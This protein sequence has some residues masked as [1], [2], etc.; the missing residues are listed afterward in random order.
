MRL[1]TWYGATI[2]VRRGT[3]AQLDGITLAA[4]ELGFTTDDEKELWVG[5]GSNNLLVGRAILDTIGNIPT[6]AVAGR[7]FYATDTDELFVD[8]GSSWDEISFDIA[9]T[10]DNLVSLDANGKPQDS[11]VAVDDAGTTTADLWTASKIQTEIDNAVE[12][13]SWKEPASVMGLVGNAAASTIE[14]LSPSAGDSYVVTTAD[15]SGELA[16][17]TVGDIWEYNGSAWAKVIT[18]SGGFVPSGTRAALST[19][20][21]LISPY[22]DATDDGKVMSFNGTTNTGSNTGDAAEGNAIL[23][24]G[25]NSVNEN[26]TYSFDGTVPTGSWV[27]MNQGGGLSAGN[28]ILI[29]SNIISVKPDSTTGGNVIPVDVS[30]NGVGL[31]VDDLDGTGLEVDSAT[32]RLAA[33]GNGISGGAGSTLSV[34]SDTATG[35][36]IA[37]VSVTA[38][39]VGVK[40]DN[41]SIVHDN[42]SPDEISVALVD[43]G[44]F[45]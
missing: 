2:Q 32:L 31:D 37:A 44:S 5:D 3:K 10:E 12:G 40:I 41:S 16:T 14:G 45:A 39:G 11:G 22:T 9:G 19:A 25:E 42:G 20:T 6:A 29:S 43:G 8:N 27:L 7:F 13:R 1:R 23:C 26:N 24:S 18:G 17:A 34:A 38:N 21:A 36:T 4:G 30:A 35:A 28:G 15:G 33:Q